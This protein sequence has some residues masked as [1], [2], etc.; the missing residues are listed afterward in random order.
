MRFSFT[1]FL[2]LLLGVSVPG[3]VHAQPKRVVFEHLTSADGLPENSVMA[4]LQDT[5]GFLW[6]GTENG[7][8]RYD[9]IDMTVYLPD[10]GD[11]HSIGGRTI[12][13]LYE[14]RRGD[15][16]AGTFRG[17]LSRYDRAAARFVTYRHDP[18]DPNSLPPH[19]VRF[20]H[21]DQRGQ[22][23][24]ITRQVPGPFSYL[25]RFDPAT[26]AVTR[27]RHDPNDAGS[28]SH[29]V[30]SEHV[31]N[32]N[33][34]IFAF[35]EDRN[36]A[37]WV[38]TPGGGLN[39]YDPATDAF[40]HFRHDPA[41][42]KSLG[43]DRVASVFEDRAGRLWVG[44]LG[45]GLNLMDRTTGTFTRY[46][47]DPAGANSLS[48]AAAAV[49]F[50]DR[51][52]GLWVTTAGGLDRFDPQTG[53]FTPYPLDA[54]ALGLPP[55]NLFV[56][57]HEEEGGVLWVL[58]Y[59]SRARDLHRNGQEDGLFRLDPATDTYTAYPRDP[60][61]PN[62][63]RGRMVAAHLLDRS[64][65]FWIGS[66]TGGLN[67]VDPFARR[68]TQYAPDPYAPSSLGDT[69]V[70]SIYEAPTEPGV[71]WIGTATGLDRL[72]RA[73]GRFTHYRPG[74]PDVLY[75]D[76][77]F[78]LHEDRAGRFWVGTRLSGLGLMDRRTGQITRYIQN[79]DNPDDPNQ[80]GGRFA[81]VIFED[82]AGQL[83]FGT[84][85]L[86]RY[87]PKTGIFT[88]F[89]HDPNDATSL[90]HNGVEVLYED[91]TGTLWVGSGNGGLSRFNP[92]TETFTTYRDRQNGPVSVHAL[93][94]DTAGRFW[95][96]DRST[97]LH[98]FDRETGTSTT[99]TVA[100]GLP[101]NAVFGIVEDAQGYLWITTR[102]GLARFD[103]AT[104]AVRTFGVPASGCAFKSAS[105]EIFLCSREGFFAF[106]PDQIR[107]N[108][109]PPQVALTG[110]RLFNEPVG[111]GPDSLLETHV[112]IAEQITLRHDQND[113]TFDY[114]GLHFNKPV[115]NTYKYRLEG[116]EAEW[117]EV[118]AQRTAIYPNLPHGDYTFRV[119]AAN[120]DGVWNEEGASIRV[121]I[122]PPWW[123]TTWAYLLYGLLFLGGVF[124]VDRV[125]RRRLIRQE[126]EKARIREAQLQAEAAEEK[127]EVLA[128]L[129]QMKTR[130]FV[131]VS[132]EFRTPL[133]LILGPLHD[134]LDGA[135]GDL[136]ESLRPHLS[137]MQRN[138][139]RLLRLINQLLDL[140]KLEA[141]SMTLRVRRGNLVSFLRR[142]VATF[143]SRAER[144]HIDLQFD[145]EQ[146]TIDLYFEPDKLEKV[147]T[148]L[149][150]NAFK[151]TPE[152]GTIRVEVARRAGE[153]GSYVEV[154][155]GDT[156]RGI[157]ADEL[158]YIFDRFTS[159][160]LR[161]HQIDSSSTREHEGTGIGLA[162]VKELV[163][164]HG[165]TVQV[166]S[167][168]GVGTT[169]IVRLPQGTDHLADA[170]ILDE[171]VMEAEALDVVGLEASLQAVEA[172]MEAGTETPPPDA[173][174][175]LI[176][177]DNADVRAYLKSHLAGRYRIEEA[178]DGVEGLEMT[179]AMQPA[180]VISDVMMPR[181]DG[182]E[183]C[184][185]LKT[186]DALNHIPVVL[187]T[188]KADEESKVEG[189]ET[190]ADDYLYKPF[191][192]TELLVR[193][194]N[195]IEIRLR[196]R[197]RFS[198]D[199]VAVAPSEIEITSADE[200]F[201]EKV[202]AVVEA[203]L[204]DGNFGVDWL[205]GEVAM[206]K[207]QLQ[208]KM[209]ALT[210]L[211]AAGYIRSM[212][213]QRAA[214]L[215]AQGGG[216]VAEVAY[217]VGFQKVPHFSKLFR[218]VFGVIPSKYPVE[219]A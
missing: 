105:G 55:Y 151:F 121:T 6:L 219:E 114:V 140:S 2:M 47:H 39:R 30:V 23:W 187:L 34:G 51:A 169:F 181:M 84:E 190:G 148:N 4:M 109:H 137:L 173:P 168:E 214:Q 53:R 102:S 186:D 61:D 145:A 129:D 196:L 48:H 97:G 68:F 206:S 27:Y 81:H 92:E 211:T 100:D 28:L 131:N 189:L 123:R 207:R 99:Y 94:E 127:A 66:W 11:P 167:E 45:G 26:G 149:L 9:G 79:R 41:D 54:A 58:A 138:G 143:A 216:T 125:Q 89:R 64:G 218:Q 88:H 72:D 176:V 96:G 40:A 70:W 12:R 80:L 217:A 162:L 210:G 191:S 165:G 150:S 183:L 128:E 200:A 161:F 36:G 98:L 76:N 83:W 144:Q 112:S 110:L 170:E 171:V 91:R 179:R 17:G 113:L 122:N 25:N 56:P 192:A 35:L 29:D 198:R 147:V 44:T 178:A 215:L 75:P 119:A 52:G 3:L 71:L 24:L 67:K 82:R 46:R 133:T 193:V 115:Q 159:V 136:D 50:E 19:S 8:V 1:V 163:T 197:Q 60:K 43:D 10:A 158:S 195:L 156:G 126:R 175:I 188:A 16:W 146:G 203:H 49:F 59:L 142:L 157:P 182:Y 124:A 107:D 166:E 14:D 117:R 185:L 13:A 164:L 103:P 22:F 106:H 177:E 101:D 104:R 63:L 77:I 90:S 209:Q 69:W 202:Q 172:V 154:V 38:G 21:E 160:N 7:L 213:L 31:R 152:G 93:H 85:G 205:A 42:P 174:T 208:R 18:N 135:F 118:G 204:G 155:I 116:Y 139:A 134:A 62:S 86:D 108:P 180:L 201:L 132:H 32:G 95:V 130:F 37:I 15:L 73:T 111:F 141:G 120:S 20:I 184:R 87:D 33:V 74:Y 78:A 194:E 5:L 153:A 199:V 65:V 212:R 57:I